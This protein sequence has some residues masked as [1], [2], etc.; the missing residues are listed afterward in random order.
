MA[1]AILEAS[2]LRQSSTTPDERVLEQ[3]LARMVVEATGRARAVQIVAIHA[4][5]TVAVRSKGLLPVRRSS[6]AGAGSCGLSASH[7]RR[8]RVASPVPPRLKTLQEG[9]SP[10]AR[11]E[12]RWQNRSA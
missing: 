9:N 10:N 2:V 5:T 1:H 7:V 8:P 3:T 12:W 4:T 11:W 6:V